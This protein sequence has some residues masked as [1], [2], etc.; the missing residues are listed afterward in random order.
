MKPTMAI[1]ERI[2]KNSME[3]KDEVFTRLYRYLLRPDIYY[4]AYQNLYSNKGAGTKGIDDDTA[5]GFSEKKISTIINSLASESYT[6]KPVRRTYISKKSSSKL[7]PLGLP[8]FTD[9]LIQEVL[10]L[11]LEAIYEP[12]FLDTS[13]GFRPKRSCHTALKMIKREFGGARW[14]V[15]GDIKGCFDNIDHQ[16]LISIIQKKVKDARFIKLIYKFLK[17]GYMENW[18][19]HKTYSGT[20]QGGILSPLLAN[21]YLHELDLFVL[22]LKEQFDNPQKDNITS[23]YRQAHNE[24]KR[25]SNRLKK[26]EGNEKQ[27]LLEE[28]LIKRQRLMT[29]PCTAQTDKKLKYVRYADDFI[30][31]VKGNK[32][33][34]HWLK[35]QLADFINGH[36]KMTLSPEK[37]LITHSSNCARFLGYDIRVRRSQAIK[38]GGSGQVKKMTLNGSVELLIPFKDKIHLFLFNKGIVIQKNDGSYFPVHRKNILTATDLEIVTIYNSELRGICRYYGLTSNFNQLN[39]FAYLMEYSCLK[40]LASKHKTSLVKIRA[41]YKDGFGSWA[42]PYETKTTKKRMY[43]TDYTKCK[44]PS[45]FTDL[46]SSVAV[47]Y[48]YSRTTFESRL[49]AKKCELCGTTDKQTTYEIHHVN[50][51]KN[52]KGKEKWEQMMI[53]KQRKTLVVCHH[54]HRHVIHNH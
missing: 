42:I 31:S 43:F 37:T 22:K 2:S 13:H 19:Y 52:L 8:T 30:I 20:P 50:K 5:D 12:I 18:N 36:L 7:R 15:E 26:V 29:I 21:I 3:Q 54:C 34:C 44:S 24:L 17:A 48:G 14:F 16:V 10:R 45:T 53:A 39:Y 11:I 33:D 38:R 28:Y 40:T 1:L 23:E 4:I 27:E 47:T 49:K 6:P 46:K 32:K 25:L 51:G 41:K 35:Q 9:K